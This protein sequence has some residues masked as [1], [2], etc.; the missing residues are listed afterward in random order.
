MI[1]ITVNDNGKI[2]ETDSAVGECPTAC[3]GLLYQALE[4]VGQGQRVDELKALLATECPDYRR[5]F[6]D[7]V[8]AAIDVMKVVLNELEGRV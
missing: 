6:T 2:T 5:G 8:R 1:K 3:E 4:R 7:G